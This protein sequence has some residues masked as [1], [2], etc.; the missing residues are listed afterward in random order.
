MNDEFLWG[1][2]TALLIATGALLIIAT[3]ITVNGDSPQPHPSTC[4]TEPE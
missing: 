1:I 4:Q 3:A 2:A